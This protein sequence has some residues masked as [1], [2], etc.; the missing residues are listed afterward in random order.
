MAAA[1][2]API[3]SISRRESP[4]RGASGVAFPESGAPSR[5][6]SLSCMSSIRLRLRP[7]ESTPSYRRSGSPSEPPTECA[8][9]RSSAVDGSLGRRPAA[10][11]LREAQQPGVRRERHGLAKAQVLEQAEKAHFEEAQ[12]AIPRQPALDVA[13]LRVEPCE[14]APK[15]GERFREEHVLRR[16]ARD[17]RPD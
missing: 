13:E 2:A 16:Q 10:E 3:A 17:L 9:S 5:V 1:P 8:S 15:P 14:R 7:L 12:G 11:H 6:S 4:G